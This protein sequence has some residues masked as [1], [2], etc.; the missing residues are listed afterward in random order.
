MSE[1]G[2][3]CPIARASEV[4]AERWTPLIVREILEGRHHFG[5]ILKGVHRASPSILQQRLRQLERA[6][7][8]DM[9]PNPHG[10]GY[11]YHLTPAGAEMAAVIRALGIW[12]QRWLDLG[13]DHLDADFLMWKIFH[14]LE[15][16]HMPAQRRV[17]RFEFRDA[18]KRYWL[19]LRVPDPDLCYTDPGFGDDLV[20][21]ASLE[22]LTRVF[23]GQMALAEAQ[24]VGLISVD[25]PHVL[26]RRLGGWLP[27]SSLA[28]YARQARFDPRRGFI[29]G[30]SLHPQPATNP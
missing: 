20:V 9:A 3:F 22:A 6:G 29:V 26:A 28:G 8:I 27:V 11:V 4:F 2:Q 13:R 5:E 17:L 16:N 21:S 24:R 12:G 30:E 14:H 7:V 18:P 10:R 23:L 25:G 15:P 19:V 1:Y